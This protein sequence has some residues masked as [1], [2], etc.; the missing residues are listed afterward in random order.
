MNLGVNIGVIYMCDINRFVNPG[1]GTLMEHGSLRGPLL[2][3]ETGE[4]CILL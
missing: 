1:V 3:G 2:V 4:I